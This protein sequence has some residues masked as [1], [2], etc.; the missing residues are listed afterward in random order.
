MGF[1]YFAGVRPLKEQKSVLRTDMVMQC[2][3]ETC[4]ELRSPCLIAHLRTLVSQSDSSIQRPRSVY[5]YT[6]ITHLEVAYDT[7]ATNNIIDTSI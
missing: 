7:P 4:L 1:G 2:G 3:Q 6:H 5:K